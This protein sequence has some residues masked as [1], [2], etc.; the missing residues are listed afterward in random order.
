MEKASGGRL[1][2]WVIFL[3]ETDAKRLGGTRPSHI[4]EMEMQ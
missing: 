1:A 3:V 2:F 4:T